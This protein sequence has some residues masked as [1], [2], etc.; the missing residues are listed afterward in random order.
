MAVKTIDELC[1]VLLDKRAK[2]AA[3]GGEKAVAKHKAKGSLTARERIDLLMDEG[4]FVELDEFVE[5]R[6]TNFGMENKKYLGDGVVTGYGTVGGRIVYVFSQDFTVLGGSLGQMHAAKICKVMDLAL[7]NGC[8]IVG[9]NDSGGARIQEAVDALD[10]YGGI[11]YRNTISSGIIPQMSVIVG[12]TA[13]GAVYSPALTDYIFMVDK[14]SIMHITGPAVIKTVTGEEISSEELGGAKTHNSRSGNA[15]FFAASEQ[16]C[17]RQV[18]DVLSYLPSNNMG[19]APRVA[20]SDPVSRTE[21]ALRTMVPTDAN[22]GYDVHN[23]I[24][25][26]V[27]DGKFVEVQAMWAKN[28]VIG[29][30]SFDGMPVGIVANQASVMAGC[31]DIDC[32]DKASRFI[33]HCDAFNLPIVTF[34]DVP[35]Y[36]PGKAQEWG[37]IIRHGAKMLYAYSEATVPLITVVMRKAYG[38]AYIGMCSKALGAD[39]VLAWPQS[40]IAV[41]GAAGAANIIFRK[42]IE[43]AKDPQAERAELISEYEDA[44]ATPYQAASRG[45]VDKV[46]LPEE[47]RYEVIQALKAHRTKRQALPRKKHGVMPN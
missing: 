10:G 35:G 13:G 15:H 6:C 28:I 4:S 37:G 3:G 7:R 26:V 45:Y 43:A 39:S 30:A 22:K 47:T 41:M 25:A 38:G 11:F 8:P 20:T 5:H 16:E 2:A 46:I 32:S 29:Y 44:F 23:V 31:L 12:P 34:V 14:I 1:N 19:D 17:F 42:E 40:Q 24:K 9:I 21:M 18:R 33:R 36:L 27:D